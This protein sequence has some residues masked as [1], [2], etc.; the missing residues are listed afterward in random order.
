MRSNTG[1]ERFTLPGYDVEELVG[2]GGSGEVWR[3]REQATGDLV[4]LKRLRPR[5]DG[6]AGLTPAGA[7]ARLRREAA[8]LAT[9]EHEHVVRLR[10]VV[11]D[12]AGLTL[13]L[14]FAAGGS[15]A[16]VLAARGRLTPGEVMTIAAPLAQ[17]LA[18]IHARGLRHGD[19]TPGNILFDAEG[20]PLLADLGVAGLFG[21]QGGADGVDVATGAT[22]G[23][24]DPAVAAGGPP[25]AASDV[26]GLAA[27]CY[28]ALCGVAPYGRGSAPAPLGS[29]VRDLPVEVPIDLLRIVELALAPEPQLRPTATSFAEALF[30]CFE[31]CPPEPVRLPHRRALAVGEL[32]HEA[33]PRPA[34]SSSGD[35]PAAPGRHRW[36]G[37]RRSLVRRAAFA[38]AG[39]VALGVAVV[40]GASLAS[41]D[42]QASASAS[43]GA[44]AATTDGAWR[45]VLA[46]LDA[47]RDQAFV[48]ADPSLLEQVYAPGSAALAA[49]RASLGALVSAGE[50]ARDLRLQ[51]VAVHAGATASNAGGTVTLA[52]R[53]TLPPYDIVGTDGT[54]AHQA[55]RGERAWV[56]V[57]RDVGSGGSGGGRPEWR[58]DTIRP[59]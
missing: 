10:G 29:L 16:S 3:A 9:V 43:G 49:D 34:A 58:I 31:A 6:G 36:S 13:V 27:V 45:A 11:P 21:E 47:L 4:A 30:G 17:A 38:G 2:L 59:G 26:H 44:R 54:V 8:L 32:T 46:R 12:A 39:A 56:V 40:L 41:N 51:L 15:L 5:L 1:V 24:A 20:R 25:T 28:A 7:Q 42:Q 18:D 23:F 48:Q 35:R 57:L 52:V 53:D 14:D 33:K 19:V 50:K 22:A 55:G 37:P